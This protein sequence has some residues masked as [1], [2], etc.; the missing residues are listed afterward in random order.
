MEDISVEDICEFL[1]PYHNNQNIFA[2]N[3]KCNNI[4]QIFHN[5]KYNT[6]RIF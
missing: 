1:A 3:D 5:L 4:Y 2:I 6:E